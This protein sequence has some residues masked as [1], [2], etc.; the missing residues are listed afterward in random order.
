[1][2]KEW[3]LRNVIAYI[4]AS[5]NVDLRLLITK[6]LALFLI[7]NSYL[8]SLE[9]GQACEKEL[10]F[11]VWT[12]SFVMKLTQHCPCNRCKKNCYL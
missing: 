9:V 3:I 2:G 10:W 6:V 12:R 4:V 11:R 7:Y 1:M 5:A 8:N